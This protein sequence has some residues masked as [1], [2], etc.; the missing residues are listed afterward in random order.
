[1]KAVVCRSWGPLENLTIEDL[2][3]PR[4][5]AGEVLVRVAAAGVNFRDTLVVAGTYQEKPPL[6]LIPG[7]EVAGV[8]AAV[9]DGVTTFREGDR[10]LANCEFGGFAEYVTVSATARTMAI[11]AS[12]GFV[13]AAGFGIAYGTALSALRHQARLQRGETLLVLGAGGGVGLAACE[14]GALL[15]ARVIAAA[16]SA[17]K[18]AAATRAG[19]SATIDYRREPLRERIDALSEARGIDVVFDPVGGDFFDQS[20]RALAWN[21]RLVVVGFASGRIPTLRMNLLLLKGISVHGVHLGEFRDHAPEAYRALFDDLF[22]WH[23]EGLLV[24][25]ITRTVPLAETASVLADLA[26]GRVEGKAVVSVA[27]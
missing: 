10:V 25:R 24:P 18:L 21:G 1:M 11:P 19:A 14:L 13:D 15:G 20:I 3:V 9:G 4:P 8:V 2:P 5:A 6:P 22:R 23:A 27:P 12:M 7:S 16:G 17:D 26:A